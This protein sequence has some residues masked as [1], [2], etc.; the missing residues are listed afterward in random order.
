MAPA[1]LFLMPDSSGKPETPTAAGLA[2]LDRYFGIV[3]SLIA[4][5][6]E[7]GFKPA[8]ACPNENCDA[9]KAHVAWAALEAG[10]PS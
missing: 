1:R 3:D 4:N 2:A 9:R 8:S 7:H 6:C 5:G 10:A